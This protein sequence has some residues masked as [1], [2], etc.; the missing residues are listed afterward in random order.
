MPSTLFNYEKSTVRTL[1]GGI[2]IEIVRENRNDDTNI[3]YIPYKSI[4]AIRYNK[5]MAGCCDQTLSVLLNDTWMNI[6][7]DSCDAVSLYNTIRDLL[8]M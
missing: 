4:R 2:E 6:K 1:S 7:L 5:K 3:T 8:S